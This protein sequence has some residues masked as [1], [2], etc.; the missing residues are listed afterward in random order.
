MAIQDDDLNAIINNLDSSW[1]ALEDAEVQATDEAKSYMRQRWDVDAI[2]QDIIDYDP[3]LTYSANQQVYLDAD[4]YVAQNYTVGQMV[5]FTDNKVYLCIANASSSQPPPNNTYWLLLGW[6]NQ[7]F[8]LKNPYPSFESDKCYPLGTN[9][10]WQGYIYQSIR[11]SAPI[12]HESALQYDYTTEYPNVNCFPIPAGNNQW[13]AGVPYSMTGIKPLDTATAWNNATTYSAGQT[14]SYNNQIWQSLINNN[15]NLTPGADIVSWQPVIWVNGDRRNKQL[16]LTCVDVAL[17][18]LH[19]GIAP[20]NVPFLREKRYMNALKWL[21]NV[22]KQ[23]LS[24]SEYQLPKKQPERGN[25]ILM[26]SRPKMD[27]NY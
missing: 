1:Q 15:L 14:A 12:G 8:Y 4:A 26:G 22:Q 3:T 10:Y 20:A 9:I 2:F 18:N 17:Y 6:L 19:A 13:S 25:R 7:Y 21:E 5:A 24:F 23:S 27:N 16:V 11:S